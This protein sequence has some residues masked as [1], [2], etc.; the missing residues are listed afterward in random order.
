MNERFVKLK[1][2]WNPL[3]EREK[4]ALM[5]GGIALGVFLFYA[6]IWSPYLNR[7]ADLRAHLPAQQK[8]LHWMQTADKE[9]RQLE[10]EHTPKTAALSPVELLAYLQ[11]QLT[12]AGL[13]ASQLKQISNDAVQMQL[14]KVDFDRLIGFLIKVAQEQSV[15]ITQMS[16]MAD[17]SQG[18]VNAGITLKIV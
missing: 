2:W 5:I 16:V 17:G 18:L 1:E 10:S 15:S 12:T 3:A 11:K 7:I 8:T 14:Q 6:L 9:I 13:D 4:R